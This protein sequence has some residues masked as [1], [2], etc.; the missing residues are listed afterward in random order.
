MAKFVVVVGDVGIDVEDYGATHD[1]EERVLPSGMRRESPSSSPPPAWTTQK[2]GGGVLLGLLG[3]TAVVMASSGALRVFPFLV[4][5]SEPARPAEAFL[6]QARGG[7]DDDNCVPATG[8]WPAGAV[9]LGNNGN[10]KG[11]TGP[12]VTCFTF[13]GNDAA[14]CWSH[15]YYDDGDWNAC[16]PQGYGAAG[17]QIDDPHDDDQLND[18][19]ALVRHNHP[20]ESCGTPCTEFTYNDDDDASNDGNSKR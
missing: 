13:A 10:E 11:H 15:S 17:W 3:L 16:T 6:L 8:P 2:A 1:D 4:T 9:S 18:D 7:A 19:K 12:F 14:Q 5:S 20:L